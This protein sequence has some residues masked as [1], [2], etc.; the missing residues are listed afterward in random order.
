MGAKKLSTSKSMPTSATK[1]KAP[2]SKASFEEY[3]GTR[4]RGN[5]G[6]RELGNS[7]TRE[8]GKGLAERTL[9]H[10]QSM[11]MK[12]QDE[13]T[14]RVTRRITNRSKDPEEDEAMEGINNFPAVFGS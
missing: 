5:S 1:S 8:L 6:T 13:I 11:F 7:G 10:I 9:A 4:E 14:T 2:K 12:P 3:S